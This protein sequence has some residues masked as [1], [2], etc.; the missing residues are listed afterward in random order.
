[1]TAQDGVAKEGNA[2][3]GY[4]GASLERKK[5]L[6]EEHFNIDQHFKM[7]G[8]LCVDPDFRRDV[9]DVFNLVVLIPISIL[10]LMN[11]NWPLILS[12]QVSSVQKAWV[13]DHFWSF[14]W[15]S[16]AYL[17]IDLLWA[18]VIKGEAKSPTTYS[19]CIT[20]SSSFNIITPL[21]IV[22]L[23]RHVP[24]PTTLTVYT[25]WEINCTHDR[26]LLSRVF[27]CILLRLNEHV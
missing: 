20:L 12:F 7:I 4:H 23:E 27:S 9:H 14:W 25:I 24:L 19:T 8:A 11:W 26:F 22:Q 1:M 15:A 13:G 3:V 10:N 16:S 17:L 6:I 5:S 18:T 21:A 2:P